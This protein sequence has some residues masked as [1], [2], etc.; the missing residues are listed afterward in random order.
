MTN[1]ELIGKA[2]PLIKALAESL[3]MEVCVG[4]RLPDEYIPRP[5]YTAHVGTSRG[6]YATA[7][8]PFA[9]L[10]QALANYERAEEDRRVKAEVEAE[11]IARRAQK[12]AA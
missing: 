12:Q 10:T 6:G 5:L 4:F 11:I 8:T 1:D 9:A 3:G 7:D 2:A